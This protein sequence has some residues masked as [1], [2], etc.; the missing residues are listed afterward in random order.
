MKPRSPRS[1]TMRVST[2]LTGMTACAAVFMPVAAAHAATR[3]ALPGK[4]E[5]S[6]AKGGKMVRVEVLPGT[7]AGRHQRVAG[8][9]NVTPAQPYYLDLWLKNSVTSFHVCGWHPTN[10][11]RCTPTYDTP[12]QKPNPFSYQ[13]VGHN[14]HSWDRGTIDIYWN[15]GGPGHW[16]T[17]N[18]NGA[19]NGYLGQSI[20][21]HSVVWLSNGTGGG[22]GNGVPTC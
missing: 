20:S 7:N 14:A 16:D 5:G 2:A 8:P 6:T 4:T 1:K 17:C 21:V 10:T 12:G 19:Y 13:D 18:T 9:D 22:I 11:W 3:S 15:G